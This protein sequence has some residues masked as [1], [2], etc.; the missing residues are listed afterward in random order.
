MS[1]LQEVLDARERDQELRNEVQ[2]AL[3]AFYL[4]NSKL[5]AE[6]R[7]EHGWTPELTAATRRVIRALTARGENMIE[8]ARRYEANL[9][10]F[11]SEA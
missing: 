9:A 7:D 6:A 10:K 5:P 2:E 4:L 8:E 1:V 3:R 11:E